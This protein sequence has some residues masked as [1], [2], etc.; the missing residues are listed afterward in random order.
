MKNNVLPLQKFSHFAV[1]AAA[2]NSEGEHEPGEQIGIA[3]IEEGSRM[4]RL[5]LFMW[6]SEQY[7]IASE[8]TDSKRYRALSLDE[9]T[10]NSGETRS[11]WN[12]I[13]FGELVGCL[14]KIRLLFP[15]QTIFVNLY[16]RDARED[17]GRQVVD[18]AA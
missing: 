1:H 15:Q 13:G 3:F 2:V 14:I 17:S 9:Y 5:K 8:D 16:P 4:F 18:G 10:A 6:P 7:F 12:E 11:K